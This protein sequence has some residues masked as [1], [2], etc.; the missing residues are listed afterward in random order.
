MITL[1]AQQ[2]KVYEFILAQHNANVDPPT[3]REIS[4]ATNAPA[5]LVYRRIVALE[6]KGY[7]FRERYG[8]IRNIRL[9]VAV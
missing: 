4:I 9:L 8:T 7:L 1:T 3:I 6:K 5:S 2:K